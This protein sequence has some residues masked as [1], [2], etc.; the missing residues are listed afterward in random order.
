MVSEILLVPKNTYLA[1]LA[2]LHKAEATID[3]RVTFL[4]DESFFFHKW[5]HNRLVN[6]AYGII[7]EEYS[8]GS[9][10]EKQGDDVRELRLLVRGEVSVYENPSRGKR[11][12]SL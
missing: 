9:V 10:I 6:L 4:K 12:V 7:E 5:K 3:K 2:A 8:R 1:H 11:I